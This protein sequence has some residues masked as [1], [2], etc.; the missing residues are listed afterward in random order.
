MFSFSLHFFDKRKQPTT[1]I[2]LGINI[3][4]M[5]RK[6]F[7]K[8]LARDFRKNGYDNPKDY[9][10]IL[11]NLRKEMPEVINKSKGRKLPEFLTME[12]VGLILNTAYSLRRNAEDEY[13]LKKGLITETYIKT[14]LRNSELC[15]LRIEDIDFNTCIFKVRLGKGNKDRLGIMPK[16]LLSTFARDLLKG[17]KSGYLFLNNRGNPFSTRSIQYIIQEIKEKSGITKKIHPHSLRHTFATILKESGVELRDIQKL[18]GHTNIET[19]TIY[20]HMSITDKREEILQIT[21]RF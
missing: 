6:I 18:L 16:G 3:I 12:E 20:E 11:R 2:K 10:E 4:F 21:D 17:R 13:N 8:Q 19:T 5:N 15:N 7:A 1:F 14:G 9:K